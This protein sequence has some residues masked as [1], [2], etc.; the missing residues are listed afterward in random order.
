MR[1]YI[2]RADSHLSGR[3]SQFIWGYL[4]IVFI[5][6]V[7]NSIFGGGSHG[8]HFRSQASTILGT[9]AQTILTL[10]YVFEMFRFIREDQFEAVNIFKHIAEKIGDLLFLVLGIILVNWAF[11]SIIFA[12]IFGFF[13]LGGFGVWALLSIISSV[14]SFIINLILSYLLIIYAYKY[15]NDSTQSFGT[16][17]GASLREAWEHFGDFFRI[18]VHYLWPAYVSLF[19][20]ILL[21][22]M[23]VIVNTKLAYVILLAGTLFLIYWTTRFYPAALL[24]K[25]Y[26]Y[27]D[28]RYE[29]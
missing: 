8:F 23:F 3:L 21:A 24:A 29:Y 18:D 5:S 2:E 13:R 16:R 7:V 11:S 20:S 22:L 19:G 4:L 1:K 12:I 15:E 14:V 27:I 25:S 6:A 28:E 9:T 26:Y 10:G 17:F